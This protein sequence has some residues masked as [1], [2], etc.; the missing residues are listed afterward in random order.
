MRQRGYA[1]AFA[2]VLVAVVGGAYFGGRFVVQR[3]RQDF[4]FRRE[5]SPPEL[6]TALPATQPPELTP[7]PQAAVATRRPTP[8]QVVVPT[9]V[10][11]TPEP[12]TP[13]VSPAATTTQ[14]PVGTPETGRETTLP[15]ENPTPL[16]TPAPSEPFAVNGPVRAS[17]GDCGG[18]YVLGLITSRGGD[19]LPGVRLRLVD[20]FDNEAF[21][22]T[23]SG[24]ADLGRYDFPVA[25]PPRRFSLSVVDEAGSA[26]SRA[27]GFAYYGDAADA[28]ATC[29]WVDW[30]RR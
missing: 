28:Q 20:E 4:Q 17:F 26:L 25:G 8:T 9:P 27:A 19:P 6:V 3:F 23:K 30:Q 12:Y 5:W 24:Q 13:P 11:P 21:A 16:P 18:T 15:I 22:V 1:V 7:L 29:Y 14:A 2:L 10:A